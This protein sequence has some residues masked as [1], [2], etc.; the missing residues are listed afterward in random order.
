M[1][2][3]IASRLEANVSTLETLSMQERATSRSGC[4]DLY[5][6]AEN[7]IFRSARITAKKGGKQDLLQAADL[8][9]QAVRHD[10]SFFRRILSARQS[11]LSD[12]LLWL[13]PYPRAF[14]RREAAVQSATRLRPDAG[15]THL[16]RAENLYAGHLDYDGALQNWSSSEETCP[17]TRG[18]FSCSGYPEAPGSMG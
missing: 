3:S 17:M 2:Q 18:Y 15:E 14:P 13:G 9:N 5:T 8:L 7:L 11:S 6:R 12:L 10:P 16:A 1:A 4:Y